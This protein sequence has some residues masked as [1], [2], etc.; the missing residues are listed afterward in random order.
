MIKQIAIMTF[1]FALYGGNQ[2]IYAQNSIVERDTICNCIDEFE[3]HPIIKTQLRHQI[4]FK[5][6]ANNSKY[7]ITWKIKDE[8]RVYKDTLDC[9]IPSTYKPEFYCENDKYIVLEQYCGTGCHEKIFLPTNQEQ[10]PFSRAFVL[11]MDLDKELIIHCDTRVGGTALMVESISSNNLQFINLDLQC[12]AA[13]PV[14]CIDSLNLVGDSVYVN[15]EKE[16]DLFVEE[17]IDLKLEKQY[18]TKNKRH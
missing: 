17:W 9:K 7:L 1:I 5:R 4:E 2:L 10:I 3:Y 11:Y 12:Q 8:T 15:Y 14:W 16:E 18:T 13:N 6:I